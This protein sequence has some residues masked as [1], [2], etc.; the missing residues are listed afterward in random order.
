VPLNNVSNL[1]QHRTAHAAARSA[2]IPAS[3]TR[4]YLVMIGWLSSLVQMCTPSATP[5]PSPHIHKH[6]TPHNPSH[7]SA[8][9]PPPHKT[10]TPPL[11][12]HSISYAYLEL[13][14]QLAPDL[15]IP[16]PDASAIQ[17]QHHKVGSRVASWACQ[18]STINTNRVGKGTL[19]H[20]H[21]V[22]VWRFSVPASAAGGAVSC[23][24]QWSPTVGS[25]PCK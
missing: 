11:P 23:E 18:Q 20:L 10:S 1:Q 24:E 5:P 13:C 4:I 8:T 22:L 16:Q 17:H 2:H 19:L 12:H 6:H 14:G 25:W 21:A 3:T 7:F 9:P 15:L